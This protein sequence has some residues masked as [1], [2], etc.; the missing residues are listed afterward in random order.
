MIIE[1]EV[2]LAV[3][4]EIQKQNTYFFNLLD[5]LVEKH[6]LNRADL[7]YIRNHKDNEVSE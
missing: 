2:F 1:T 3:L 7:D 4:S 5:V 6:I